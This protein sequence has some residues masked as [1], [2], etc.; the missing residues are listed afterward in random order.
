MSPLT[1]NM[2]G[3]SA[4]LAGYSCRY[5]GNSNTREEIKSLAEEGKIVAVCPEVLGGLSIPREPAEIVG[6]NAEDVICGKAKIIT[7]G[8]KDVTS[9][10][11]NGALRAIKLLEEKGV[12]KVYLKEKSPSC[13]V[14]YVYDGSFSR[15]LIKGCGVFAELLKQ[16]GINVDVID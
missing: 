16:K 11:L 12:K 10:Y 7:I 14:E 3:A 8:G 15:R 13:G 9:Q 4:C 5:D 2:I 6:G 1:N